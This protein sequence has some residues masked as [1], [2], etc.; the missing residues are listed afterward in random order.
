MDLFGWL[1]LHD[2]YKDWRSVLWQLDGT[3]LQARRSFDG[4][5]DSSSRQMSISVTFGLGPIQGRECCN[6]DFGL[7]FLDRNVE[8]TGPLFEFT[9]VLYDLRILLT[10]SNHSST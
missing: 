7:D 8:V 5:S 3:E 4:L 9:I 6:T 1:A 10:T 2:K